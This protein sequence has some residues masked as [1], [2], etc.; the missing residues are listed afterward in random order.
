MDVDETA[1]AMNVLD[2]IGDDLATNWKRA[3]AD[4][5]ELSGVLGKGPLGKRFTATYS[6]ARAALEKEASMI[7]PLSKDMAAAGRNCLG[8]Y[9]SAEAHAEAELLRVK[10]A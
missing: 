8:V 9:E 6:P 2:A 1:R 5:A 4:I 7:V 3:G 10:F